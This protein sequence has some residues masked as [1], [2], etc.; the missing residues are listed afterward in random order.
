M[1]NALPHYSHNH[2]LVSTRQS[3]EVYLEVQTDNEHIH[4]DC[5]TSLFP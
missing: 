3:P 1:L 4:S 5:I 2:E